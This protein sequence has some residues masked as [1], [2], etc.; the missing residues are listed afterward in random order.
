MGPRCVG[1][2]LRF[3]SGVECATSP[4]GVDLWPIVRS[5]APPVC[6]LFKKLMLDL[7]NCL[8]GRQPLVLT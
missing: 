6:D 2:R 5:Y 1:L 7:S 8:K 4:I 3:S